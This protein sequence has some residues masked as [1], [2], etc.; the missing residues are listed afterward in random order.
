[1]EPKIKDG[2]LVLIKQQK[3]YDENNYVFVIHNQLPKLK[4]I[5]KKNNKYYLE[6]INRFFENVELSE[7]DDTNII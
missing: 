4:K 7:Y 6:S 5:I 3:H 2:D 1:M